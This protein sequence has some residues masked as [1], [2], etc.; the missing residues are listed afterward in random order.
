MSLATAVRRSAAISVSE[1]PSDDV[2]YSRF[3]WKTTAKAN[4]R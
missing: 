4:P 1:V 3:H 2:L